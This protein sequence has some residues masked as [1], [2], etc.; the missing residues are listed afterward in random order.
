[1]FLREVLHRESNSVSFLL[2]ALT[3]LLLF[4][5]GFGL[6]AGVLPNVSAFFMENHELS[7][8]VLILVAIVIQLLMSV[9]VFL[10]FRDIRQKEQEADCKKEIVV[11]CTAINEHIALVKSAE[12][13][14]SIYKEALEH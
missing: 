1:M 9:A 3:A 4:S 12:A 10:A 6:I 8:L 5:V 7:L 14:E 13:M 11:L 2:H